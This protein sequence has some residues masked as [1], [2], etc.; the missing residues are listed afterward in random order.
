MKKLLTAAVTMLAGLA[1]L[2]P[3]GSA[4][5]STLRNTTWCDGQGNGY[6]LAPGK[7]CTWWPLTVQS[8][9]AFWDITKSGS[10]NVC[11]SVG[12]YQGSTFVT[13]SGAGWR[14]VPVHSIHD[15]TSSGG[16]GLTVQNYF[17]AAYGQIAILNYSSATIKTKGGGGMQVRYWQ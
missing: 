11:L 10:G 8:G 9:Y 13:A 14:C 17:G 4:Q 15:G 6:T 12:N 3:A 16:L 1:F 7:M 2:L 5:A